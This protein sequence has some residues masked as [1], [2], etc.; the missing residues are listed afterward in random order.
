MPVMVPAPPGQGKPGQEFGPT[1]MEFLF[2]D[3]EDRRSAAFEEALEGKDMVLAFVKDDRVR[4]VAARFFD[5]VGV[6]DQIASDPGN[7]IMVATKIGVGAV[8]V[9][10]I[11]REFGHGRG[12]DD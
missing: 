5:D 8:Q 7:A 1:P 6:F 3:P 9:D 4:F 12:K 11:G 10:V 2:F